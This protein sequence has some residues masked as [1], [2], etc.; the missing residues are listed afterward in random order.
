[1]L[2]WSIVFRL[3]RLPL[4]RLPTKS[5]IRVEMQKQV[6]EFLQSGGEVKN[7]PNGVSGRLTNEGPFRNSSVFEP[8]AEERTFIPEVVAAL[9]ERSKQLKTPQ[10]QPKKKRSAPKKVPIYDDFGEILRWEWKE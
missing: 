7:I 5:D 1:M 3:P 8:R 10:P 6:D 9:D 2:Y 4:K